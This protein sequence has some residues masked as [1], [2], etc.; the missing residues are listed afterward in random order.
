MPADRMRCMPSGM[1][2]KHR[3]APAVGERRFLVPVRPRT[4]PRSVTEPAAGEAT[5]PVRGMAVLA[6]TA[7]R[8]EPAGGGAGT[9]CTA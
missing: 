1:P 6:R 7:P 9:T 2:R 8:T 3:N 5:D 4:T